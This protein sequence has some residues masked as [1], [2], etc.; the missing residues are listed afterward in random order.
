MDLSTRLD[1]VVPADAVSE[2]PAESPERF[3]AD[4]EVGIRAAASVAEVAVPILVKLFVPLLEED[5]CEV[6]EGLVEE[7]GG[8]EVWP[9][10][11]AIP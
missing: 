2:A 4:C 7:E 6:V 9:E 11:R 8:C 3:V 5:N 10:F 1:E